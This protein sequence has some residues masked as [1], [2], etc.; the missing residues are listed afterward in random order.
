MDRDGRVVAYW[1]RG[2]QAN[3]VRPY[4]GMVKLKFDCS[5]REKEK[6]RALWVETVGGVSHMVLKLM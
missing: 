1:R 4:E 6:R 5:K 3:N 2:R